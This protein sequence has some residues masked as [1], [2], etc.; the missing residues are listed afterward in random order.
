MPFKAI[1]SNEHGQY[2]PE[3]TPQIMMFKLLATRPQIIEGP[4]TKEL[5]KVNIP[6]TLV[7]ND[8]SRIPPFWLS[9]TTDEKGVVQI[10]RKEHFSRQEVISKFQS[11]RQKEKDVVAVFKVLT[12]SPFGRRECLTSVVT[13]SRL[14]EV[15]TQAMSS[16]DPCCIQ[17]YVRAKGNYACKVRVVYE[18]LKTKQPYSCYVLTNRS[19]YYDSDEPNELDPYYIVSTTTGSNTTAVKTSTPQQNDPIVTQLESLQS[20]F[21]ENCGLHFENL[22]VDF[23][24]EDTFLNPTTP[25]QMLSIISYKLDYHKTTKLSLHPFTLLHLDD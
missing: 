13:S 8:L 12:G 20:H 5:L 7:F 10:T 22:T 11:K 1:Q 19:S 24:K 2:A 14:E 4:A 3:L 23:I 6:D 17:K 16:K 25:W 21:R 9:M 15:L 18:A